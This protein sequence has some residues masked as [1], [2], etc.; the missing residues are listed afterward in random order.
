VGYE[1]TEGVHFGPPSEYLANT[2]L[3][4]IDS[5]ASANAVR[6]ACLRRAKNF[7][8][9]LHPVAVE[10]IVARRSFLAHAAPGLLGA[11]A[12]KSI[13][14]THCRRVQACVDLRYLLV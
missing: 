2:L 11:G 1:T 7:A 6:L 12:N 13:P 14:L 4:L 9:F 5:S 3:D 8:E 10:W